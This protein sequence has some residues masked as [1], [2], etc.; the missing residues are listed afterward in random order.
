VI[1]ILSVAV[2]VI[3][4]IAAGYL[5]LRQESRRREAAD[6]KLREVAGNL[7]GV[8]FKA[9]RDGEGRLRFPYLTGRPEPLFG[10]GAEA[11]VADAR[12]L[13]ARIHPD[14]RAGV[15]DAIAAAEQARSEI[16]ADFR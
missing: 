9:Q 3:G 1:V 7:P 6:S 16:N 12:A 4:A 13:F 8:V 2:L 15:L 14:D 5:R 10:I 11:I